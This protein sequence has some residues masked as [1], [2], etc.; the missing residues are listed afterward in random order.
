[1][2][3]AILV[4]PRGDVG[5]EATLLFGL[6]MP[7]GFETGSGFGLTEIG[8]FARCSPMLS[9]AFA[10]LRDPQRQLARMVGQ[11]RGVFDDPS[12]R[13]AIERPEGVAFG[14]RGRQTAENRLVLR[15]SGKIVLEV[16]ENLEVLAEFGVQ[17]AK[18]EIKQAIAEQHDLHL[19]RNG[20][21]LERNRAGEAEEAADVFD[22]DVTLPRPTA[23]RLRRG[24]AGRQAKR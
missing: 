1:M 22:H 10:Q 4:P 24:H 12:E 5:V 16:D 8:W 17:R 3:C 2:T 11:A 18:Q 15:R 13:F 21:G 20:I 6:S 14:D 23:A 9:E 7:A 19:Q